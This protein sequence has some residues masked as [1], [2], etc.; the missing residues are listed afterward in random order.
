M[1]GAREPGRERRSP[2][3][4]ASAS[5][6]SRSGATSRPPPAGRGVART[7]RD[8]D[9]SRAAGDAR[10]APVAAGAAVLNG[11]GEMTG[12]LQVG[13]WGALQTPV[14]LTSTM[15]VGRVYDGA[16]AAAVAAD[17]ARRRRRRRH[18][19]RRRVRRQLAQRRAR[20]PGRGGRRGPRAG[21]RRGRRRVAEGAVGAGTGMVC[22]GWKGGIGTASRR[23]AGGSAPRSAC[24]CSP[25]S[26]T[27]AELRVDGVA[28]RRGCSATA[29]QATGAGRRAA[30]SSCSPPTRRSRPRQLRAR[31]ACA[32]G[33]GW[34][35]PARSPTTAAARS[36]SRSPRTA[37]AHGARRRARRRSSPPPSMPSE[38]SVLN[39]LWAA[40]DVAG[41]DGRRFDRRCR[42]TR[43]SSSS[44][45]TG[46][47]LAT[48]GRRAEGCRPAVLAVSPVAQLA[49]VVVGGLLVAGLLHHRQR[50]QSAAIAA[51]DDEQRAARYGGLVLGTA[52]VTANVHDAAVL[53][54]APADA[55]ADVRARTPVPRLKWRSRCRAPRAGSDPG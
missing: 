28:G 26:A 49:D 3:C 29:A 47:R 22:F 18:P 37:R 4:R 33:W 50:G 32:P 21:G 23:R 54:G 12:F 2:T 24:S 7:G 31:R 27:R 15:A 11:A 8:R 9:P 51:V 53:P 39:A 36:S 19:G 52:E 34:R 6:T 35:A 40:G 42:T 25:T 45:P 13:E 5:A 46:G 30:A 48:T 55:G 17:P 44:P 20:R 1:I 10:A 38:E 16:V 14:Y 43:C 41:R